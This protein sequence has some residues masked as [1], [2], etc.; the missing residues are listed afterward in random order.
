MLFFVYNWFI[1]LLQGQ[2]VPGSPVYDNKAI[3]CQQLQK[4]FAA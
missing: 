4:T 1:C 3:H 2:T